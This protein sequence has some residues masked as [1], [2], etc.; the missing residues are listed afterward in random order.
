MMKKFFRKFLVFALVLV[1]AAGV[2]PNISEI[3]A[4][5]KPKTPKITVAASE[6]G[7]SINVTIGKIKNADGYQIVAKLP[8]SEDFT[9]VKKLEA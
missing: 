2:L 8:G 5:S 4:A 1:M 7:T 3:S 6:D 9:E